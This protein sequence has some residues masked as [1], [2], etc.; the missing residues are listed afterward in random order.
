MQRPLSSHC[1]TR[2]QALKCLT[3]VET[4]GTNLWKEEQ[5]ELHRV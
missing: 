5:C 3:S 4:P 1:Y 2:L